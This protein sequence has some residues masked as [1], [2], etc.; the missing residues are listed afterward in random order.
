MG[1][2]RAMTLRSAFPVIDRG[3]FSGTFCTYV[4]STQGRLG[5][6]VW[7]SFEEW[8]FVNFKRYSRHDTDMKK[9]VP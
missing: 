8:G 2:C 3:E 6:D 4:K 1:K 9:T 7:R 5:F